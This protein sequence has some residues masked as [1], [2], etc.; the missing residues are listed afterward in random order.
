MRTGQQFRYSRLA[1]E[2]IQ[3]DVALDERFDFVLAGHFVLS[4]TIS[5]SR[6]KLTVNFFWAPFAALIRLLLS[7]LLSKMLSKCITFFGVKII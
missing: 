3:T 6:V 2:Y 1:V 4:L 7:N 5:T